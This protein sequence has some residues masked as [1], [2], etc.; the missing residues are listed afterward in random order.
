MA[1]IIR[2]QESMVAWKQG[3]EKGGNE[4]GDPR[5]ID[6]HDRHRARPA[7][8]RQSR[9]RAVC[10]E[11]YFFSMMPNCLYSNLSSYLPRKLLDTA[12]YF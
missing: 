2:N 4:A 11:A 12:P 6:S 10:S 7:L 5:G 1:I 3:R 9:A 8:V